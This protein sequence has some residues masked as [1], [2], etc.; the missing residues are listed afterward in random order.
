[1]A[2]GSNRKSFPQQSPVWSREN[3]QSTQ[4]NK[5]IMKPMNVTK[6]AC[7]GLAAL[8]LALSVSVCIGKPVITVN[9]YDSNINGV[10]DWYGGSTLSWD[11][12]QDHTGDGGGSLYIAK[13][14]SNDHIFDV[15]SF[16]GNDWD[17]GTAYDLTLYTNL[18]LWIKWDTN[19]SMSISDFNANLGGLTMELND[20]HL[21]QYDWS[22]NGLHALPSVQIPNAA[23]NGW[24]HLNFPVSSTI[25]YIDS[26]GSI[27]FDAYHTTPW[28]GTVQFWVDDITF[29]P[30]A[31]D[32]VPP[33]ILSP[34]TKA[35]PGLNVFASTEGSLYDRQ[36]A[37]LRQNSGL[38][39]VGQA[40]PAN[41]VTYS[42]TIAGYP[43]SVNC[44]AWMFLIPNPAYL[45][46]APDWNETNVALFYLQG[47]TT[48]AT[49][50]FQYKVNEDHQQAMYSGGNETRG[51]YTNDPG[52]WNGVTPNYLESG[53]LASLTTSGGILGTWTVKFTSDTNGSIIA[54]NGSS[55]NFVIPPY[56]IGYFAEQT[57]PGF[58]VYLGMQANNADAI[59]QAV[60]YSNFAVSNTAEPF[61]ENFLTDS[62]L[63]TTNVWNTSA[64][65]GP[66]GVFVAPA[67]SAL[68]AT[69]TLPD[70]SFSLQDAA[71][72]GNPFA[73]AS[74]SLGPK[75]T[76][77]GVRSQLLATNEIPAGPTAFFEL[78]KRVP[79]QLQI[80]LPGE[81]NAP[82]TLTG[83]TGTPTTGFTT[84]DGV[85][86]TINLVDST[87]HIVSSTDALSLTSSDSTATFTNPLPTLAGGTVTVQV[88]F[89]S[90]SWT[91]TGADTTTP[92]IT[93]GTSSSITIQ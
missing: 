1:M 76:M 10:W 41:P 54:P 62:V 85:N 11:S 25:P 57:S 29:Q 42:F 23:S 7:L 66:L 82:N 79:T 2:G 5:H 83:K 16:S 73:W 75:L 38:S 13:N 43:K 20:N 47:S 56:N 37:V 21:G 14:T 67:G 17:N 28:S 55:T 6:H 89:D 24:V 33:P 22:G 65:S 77:V 15:N 87:F 49:A 63:D 58:Y 8:A 48:S 78:V 46:N 68:W 81:T 39:W 91:V 74:P 31:V 92:T 52:S 70:S 84:S 30:A 35:T 93:S 32:V 59:D 18:S 86:V 53:N 9:T 26:I 4:P 60:V 64:A 40:T 34:V 69:W 51:Y 90:G 50:H 27:I 61:S 72:L 71:T 80:L 88:Y 44:E 3:K 19:S 12:S 45:D 36:S